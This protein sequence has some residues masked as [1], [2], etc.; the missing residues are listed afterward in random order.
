VTAGHAFLL[1]AMAL[2]VA[3]WPR[4]HRRRGQRRATPGAWRAWLV[5]RR[6]RRQAIDA[7]PD[8]LRR[9]AAE[10]AAGRTLERA[11]RSTAASMPP[12]L[13]PALAVASRD[14]SGGQAIDVALERALPPDEAS[15]LLAAAFGLQRRLGGD[16]PR[17]CRELAR[18]LDDRLRVEGDVR[19][20]TAQARFSAAVV[21]LLPPVGL[22]GLLAVQPAGVTRLVTS[23]LGVL[24][25]AVAAALN[26]AGAFAIRRLVQGIA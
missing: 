3:S 8:A 18:T 21:P 22:A 15:T 10:L 6:E 12:P 5:E 7:L 2:A 4:P 23:T 9:L 13:G 16:L 11:L 14:V 24:V 1:L 26:L 20:L 19:S 17:L 25:V